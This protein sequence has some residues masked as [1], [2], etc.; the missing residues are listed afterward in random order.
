MRRS[1]GGLLLIVTRVKPR[2]V[3]SAPKLTC[4][5]LGSQPLPRV[6][7]SEAFR[8]R[9]DQENLLAVQRVSWL[10]VS[11]SFLFIAYTAVVIAKP[12]PARHDQAVRLYYTIPV[13]GLVIVAGVY[14]SIVAALV[15]MRQ[16]RREFNL[17][18]PA[19][20]NPFDAIPNHSV[21]ALGTVAIHV[22]P[23][24]IGATWIWLLA[25]GL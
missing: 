19:H 24:A 5:E 12:L 23:L 14:V 22:P 16:L 21:R 15:S 1:V 9:L 20:R 13:L 7:P 8:A 10:L 17:L 11:Q 25:A 18:E 3:A 4:L 2:L 6:A